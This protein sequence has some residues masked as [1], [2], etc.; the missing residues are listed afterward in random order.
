MAR[1]STRNTTA[2]QETSARSPTP[3]NNRLRNKR[4]SAELKTPLDPQAKTVPKKK[5]CPGIDVKIS[6]PSKTRSRPWLAPRHATLQQRRRPPPVHPHPATTGSG[7]KGNRL[8]LKLH[9]IHKQKWSPKKS[10]HQRRN[11]TCPQA[12]P[13]GPRAVLPLLRLQSKVRRQRVRAIAP[14]P[15][16]T[17][18]CPMTSQTKTT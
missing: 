13:G 14:P 6:V 10:K 1:P 9:L 12:N 18:H 17:D 4:K 2:T 7:R 15:T 8:N 3:G 11:R 16:S 5:H